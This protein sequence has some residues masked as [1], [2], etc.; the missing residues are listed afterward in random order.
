[1]IEAKHPGLSVKRQCELLELPRSTYYHRPEPE[2]DENLAL[3]R[4]IDETYLAFPFFG[5]RQMTRWLRRQGHTVNR[6]RV[7][8]LMAAMGLEAIY[9]RPNLSK[10]AKRHPIYPYLLRELAVTRANQVWATDITYIPVAGGFVY[11]WRGN[12]LAQPLRPGV[13]T[14]EHAR[15]VLLRASGATSDRG[16]RRAGDL[17]HRSRLS[18]YQRRVY[19]TSARA[20]RAAIDGRQRS[21]L[22]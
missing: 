5:S 14:V 19:P 18:V 3:M 1:M 15:R 2:S 9:R 17:Q 10:A 20:W 4:V 22:G 13:G 12:R 8:R 6:K 21:V 11:L 7:R 16:P